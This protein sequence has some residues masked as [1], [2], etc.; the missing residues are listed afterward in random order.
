[1]T[2]QPINA[3]AVV[4]GADDIRSLERARL[5]ALVGRD[6]TFAWQVHAADFQ[7][8]TPIGHIYS[9]DRYLGEIE[10]GELKY[11]MWEPQTIEVR[12]RTNMAVLRYKARLQVD[13]GQGDT[14]SL[15][16]WHTDSYELHDGFWRVVWSQATTI[17]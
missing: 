2:N 6:M 14:A 8:I 7:L 3:Q 1:M 10:A 5:K 15:H 16:C 4:A 12:L 17:R 11:L 9:R 13:S